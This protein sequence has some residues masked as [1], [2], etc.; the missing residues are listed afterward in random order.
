[1]EILDT[2]LHKRY[3]ES[4]SEDPYYCVCEGRKVHWCHFGSGRGTNRYKDCTVYFQIRAF[5]KPKAVIVAQVASHS[6]E[7]M[8]SDRLKNL[9]SGRTRDPAYLQVRDTL[10]ACD[11][12][13]NAARS[14]IRS[15]LLEGIPGRVL[16]IQLRDPSTAEHHHSRRHR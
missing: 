7:R 13:Q 15:V 9:S 1:M 6:G 16:R 10:I 8:Q 2:D 3:D 5:Y 4:G 11:T 12:K 14:C